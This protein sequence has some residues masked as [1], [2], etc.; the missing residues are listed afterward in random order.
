MKKSNIFQLILVLLC[1]VPAMAMAQAQYCIGGSRNEVATCV[2]TLP[3]G[4][5]TVIGGYTYDLDASNNVI[6]AKMILMKVDP[7]GASIL[8]QEQWGIDGKNNLIQNMII[9]HDGDIVV[10]GT[11]GRNSVYQDNTGTIMKFKS[12][13]G[14]LVWNSSL[15][16]AAATPG[17]EIFLGVTELGAA[18]GYDI[19]AVGAHDLRPY[20]NRSM[21]CVFNAAGGFKYEEEYRIPWGTD[22]SSDNYYGI[23]T[24]ADGN[25]VYMTGIFRGDYADV[26]VDYYQPNT[27]ATSGTMIWSHNFNFALPG[28]IFKNGVP[29]P[30]G[31]YL[32][33]NFFVNIYLAGDKLLIHG[34]SLHDFTY[35][36]GEGESICRMNADGT[37]SA[38]LWQIQNSSVDYANTSKIAVVDQ[39]HI[40]NVQMPSS[41]YVDPVISLTGTAT[42]S[43]I[44]EVTSL[45]GSGTAS[46]M[47]PPVK[48]TTPSGGVHS[49][50]DIDMDNANSAL[51]LAGS[52][53]DPANF[54]AND[55]YFVRTPM[56][57]P[58]YD[59]NVADMGGCIPVTIDPVTPTYV[60]ETFTPVFVTVNP[61][62]TKFQIRNLCVKKA[63]CYDDAKFDISS[64][65][66]P[67]G[68]CIFTVTAIVSTTNTVKGYEWTLPSGTV[69][70]FSSATSNT[71]TF[72]IPAG[73]TFTVKVKILIVRDT[74]PV[75]EDPCCEAYLEQDVTC[76]GDL[77]CNIKGTLTADGISSTGTGTTGTGATG[78][79]TTVDPSGANSGPVGPLGDPC[80][81][82][83]VATASVG[84]GWTITGYEWH[85]AGITY[86]ISMS[87]TLPVTIPSGTSTV[88]TVIIYAV[89]DAGMPCSLELSIILN[90]D[91]G[92]GSSG[93]AA[94]RPA[95]TTTSADDSKSGSFSVFPN[96][97]ADAV[98]ITGKNMEINHIQI[99]D[100][101]GK[102][103]MSK[104]F[105]HTR[106]AEISLAQLV[107]GSYLIKINNTETKIVTKLK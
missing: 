65:T 4:T 19:V 92:V 50:N 57:L 20:H 34:G 99:M 30:G 7:T 84:T 29:L 38:E 43:V 9:T 79:G 18:G 55:I 82:I 83:C 15:R 8:W 52:T 1:M 93:A 72:T 22:A 16:D 60:R 5:G 47:N 14:S 78:I 21:I 102:E 87:S 76:K 95:K 74:W 96:P 86:P 81:F 31:L 37:G 51:E 10:V 101:N 80:N 94:G 64:I 23:C 89:N 13:D 28:I 98:S 54:G 2:K 105:D 75:G 42:S 63:P 24:G 44:T 70:V 53:D 35:T 3:D 91:N 17:G 11:M 67:A 61:E 107:P 66:D 33:D 88:V 104:N 6:N 36:S 45:T 39:D 46:Y 12:S 41:S 71:Q 25:S 106:T 85:V 62:P 77:P 97:T 69:L 100:I 73:S 26:R 58:I 32:Q 103:L 48:F 56:S 68:N 59:C 49:L 40:F 27:T 90:C